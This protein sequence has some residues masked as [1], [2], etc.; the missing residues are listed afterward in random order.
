MTKR[1]RRQNADEIATDAIVFVRKARREGHVNTMTE[2]LLWEIA[3]E[4]GI[5][6]FSI[7]TVK[8][9]ARANAKLMNELD[10]IKF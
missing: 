5:T 1:T 4:R 10:L 8:K 9:L 2:L 6:D 7:I 3:Q